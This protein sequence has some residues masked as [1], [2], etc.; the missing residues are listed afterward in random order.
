MPFDPDNPDNY[1]LE[2]AFP[3]SSGEDDL[4][5][6]GISPHQELTDHDYFENSPNTPDGVELDVIDISDMGDGG[7]TGFDPEDIPFL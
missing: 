6:E 7:G 4:A 1:D 5:E 3:S 2:F